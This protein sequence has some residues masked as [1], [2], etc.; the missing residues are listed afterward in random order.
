MLEKFVY[1]R[2]LANLLMMMF[3]GVGLYALPNLRKESFPDFDASEILIAMEYRGASAEDVEQGICLRIEDAIDS[4]QN[5][6]EVTSVAQEGSAA[7]TIEIEDG[8]DVTEALSDIE[9][10]VDA[11]TDFPDGA[12]DPI[13]T[14]LNRSV[15]VM[16]L[17]VS[18]PMSTADLKDYC[19]DLKRRLRQ[20]PLSP[21]VEI[22]GFSDRQ[23]RIELDSDA[24]RRL[25]LSAA[26]IAT[27]IGVQNLDLPVGTIEARDEDILLRF[28]EERQ[29]P[30]D[31]ED[32]IVS[33]VPGRSE[34]RLGEIGRVVDTFADAEDQAW[35]DG[36]RAGV[37]VIKK[38]KSQD[39]LKVSEQLYRFLEAERRRNPH[40]RLVVTS[41]TSELIAQ[42]L[43]LLATN[44]WQGMVLV[45]LTLWLFFNARLSFWV[46]MSLPGL[47][48]GGVLPDA[49]LWSDDQHDVVRRT[50][51]GHR[52]ADG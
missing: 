47:H 18:G 3:I 46:V 38:T 8:A 36:E 33:G 6:K 1:H 52:C 4:V 26:E 23:L 20:L 21:I 45:F 25:G 41:D 24:L 51:D 49:D 30:H 48:H 12:E 2:T 28:V 35:L 7:I 31:I 37:L 19:E 15:A 27:T 14:Q 32:I 13:I 16:T 42:R 22:E 5:I 44:A 50:A 10:E 43:S 39:T 40:I 29:R 9:V 11:I 17:A 34:I